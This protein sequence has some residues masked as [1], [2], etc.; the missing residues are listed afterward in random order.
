MQKLDFAFTGNVY[1]NL[2]VAELVEH[3]IRRGEGKLAANGALVAETAPYTGRS[4]KDKF[5]VEELT[6]KHEID[7]GPVNQKLSMENFENLTAK[8]LS[9]IQ[10]RELYVTDTFGGAHPSHRIGVRFVT[11]YAWHS[12]FVRQLLV[13]PTHEEMESFIP[14]FTVVDLP[15]LHA[16][17][18]HDGTK[19]DVFILVNFAKKLVFIGG[20]KYAGEMKKSVFSILNYL[21]PKKGIMPMHCSANIGPYGDVALFFGLSGTGKTSLSADP[22]RNLVGDDE[23]GW[24]EDGIFNF[25]GGCYAKCIRL[26]ERYEPQIWN[27]IRYGSVLENVVIDEETRLPHYDLDTLTENTR[28]A[29]P[30]D[31]IDGAILPSRAAHP[32]HIMFLTCDA[33]GV[34]PPLSRLTPEQAMYHFLLGYTAK[35]A[36]TEAGVKEPSAT[37]ST[38]FGAPF[39]PLPAATYAK[40]LGER[41]KKHN[42]QVW[43]VN[44]GWSGG[45][46]GVGE[47]INIQFTRA[48]VNAVL[49]DQLEKAQ[50]ETEP[51]FGLAVPTSCPDVPAE[52]LLPQNTWAKRDAYAKKA[53]ELAKMFDDQAAKL[54]LEVPVPV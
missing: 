9:Y 3:A 12:L 35:I 34:L 31:Y 21:L 44:T 14:E 26:S 39:L 11:E 40:M 19:S 52:I 6:S 42:A 7:W 30:L 43:L 24:A 10:G 50:F 51:F 22:T 28:A 53:R 36:G 29:Y 37:F 46:F 1:Y 45:G 32:N 47:R 15:G 2:T 23:H 25:E 18:K 54:G 38:C 4:P 27:A 5:V 8:V 13:R 20:T 49:T 17:P 48:M 16:S 41:I 33:F